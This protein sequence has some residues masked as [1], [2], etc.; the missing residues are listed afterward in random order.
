VTR[1]FKNVGGENYAQLQWVFERT[2]ENGFP[3]GVK[4]M[5][6]AYSNVEAVEIWRKDQVDWVGLPPTSHTNLI[7]VHVTAPFHPTKEENAN[8]VEG[9]YLLRGV[10]TVPLKVAPFEKGSRV[11]LE[12][13]I[14]YMRGR[15]S[16]EGIQKWEAIGELAPQTDNSEDYLKQPNCK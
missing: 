4:A 13:A 7:P 11:N 12:K 9:T 6:R 15:C 10:P 5:Y 8:G 3:L 1:A 16:L 2:N 14:K